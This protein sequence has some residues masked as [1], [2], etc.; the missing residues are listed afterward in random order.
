MIVICDACGAKNRIP[1]KA[2]TERTFRCA[3]CKAILAYDYAPIVSSDEEDLSQISSTEIYDDIRNG[4]MAHLITKIQSIFSAVNNRHG[5]LVFLLMSVILLLHLSVTAY[6]REP[7][8]DEHYYVPEAKSIIEEGELLFPEHPSLGKLFIST[9]IL[10][11]GDNPWGW[12]VPSVIF[13]VGSLI[14]FYFIIKRLTKKSVALL[15]ILLLALETLNFVFSG[16]AMFD[17]FSLFFMLLCFLL[18]LHNRYI[19]AGTSL[20]FGA[21][22]KLTGFF[23]LLVV[24][25]HWLIVRNREPRRNIAFIIISSIVAFIIFMPITDYA[26]TREWLNPFDRL[27]HISLAHQSATFETAEYGA[28]PPIE[29]IIFGIRD[30]FAQWP[31]Y[32]SIIN[33]M[34]SFMILP[35]IGYI[36]Y[37]FWKKKTEISLFAL[38]W[39]AATYLIWILIVALTDRQT[40][41]FYFY[42]A[43]GAVCSAIAFTLNKLWLVSS[44][45]RNFASRLSVKAAIVGYLILVALFFIGLTPIPWALGMA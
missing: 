25:A 38:L 16:L 13:G 35:S 8:Y 14:V 9:G 26:A 19:L 39:F 15:A 29:W 33:P 37:D 2:M 42:P 17:V 43:V 1:E 36:L 27:A 45:M 18:Y 32:I 4:R 31:N 34:I 41:L 6:A 3:K 24:I 22:C 44:N 30:E 12:R 20:A 10:V 23:G 40:Y 7:V 28:R 5:L 11:F 21:L